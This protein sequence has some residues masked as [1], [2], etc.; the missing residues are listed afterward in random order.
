MITRTQAFRSI[1]E[2]VVPE[3]RQLDE[4]GWFDLSAIVEHA[5]AQRPPKVRRQLALFLRA[6]NWF[7]VIRYGR[8]F[9]RMVPTRRAKFLAGVERSPLLLVRR[10][11]WG[12]RT[13]VLMGYYARPEAKAEIGYRASGRGWQEIG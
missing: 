4:K 13:L 10:G 7:S 2:T 1:A 3:A 12:V 5:L 8:R 11:F 9:T 6:L